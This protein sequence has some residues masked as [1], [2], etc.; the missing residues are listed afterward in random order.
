MDSELINCMICWKRELEE[1]KKALFFFFVQKVDT[2]RMYEILED[3]RA[4]YPEELRQ[5][6]RIISDKMRI[7]A[8]A[9]ADA[10]R[11]I[12]DAEQRANQ[13][14]DEHEIVQAATDKA[15]Q[16]LAAA[17][18]NARGRS[19]GRQGLC[20]GL[21]AG[22]GRVFGRIHRYGEENRESL[23]GKGET[24]RRGLTARLF[25]AFKR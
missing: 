21:D 3:M 7:M 18:K 2:E 10:E 9:K 11:M 24:Q 12:R 20:R 5:A 14:V 17:Q 16:I 15:R 6:E 4:A 13:L 25:Y 8:D 1:S 22:C 19:R 23:S